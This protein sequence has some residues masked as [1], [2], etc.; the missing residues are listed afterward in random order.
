MIIVV[1]VDISN[2]FV[3]DFVNNNDIIFILKITIFRN[4]RNFF[5]TFSKRFDRRRIKKRNSGCNR[6][7]VVVFKVIF[8]KYIIMTIIKILIIYNDGNHNIKKITIITIVTIIIVT[9]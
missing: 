9:V 1:N 3:F 2:T 7:V 4:Y 8:N 6:F 5:W